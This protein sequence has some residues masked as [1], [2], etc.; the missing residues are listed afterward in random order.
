M[1]GVIELALIC[2]FAVVY[3]W[4]SYNLPILAAGVRN[5]IR[6]KFEA[7]SAVDLWSFAFCSGYCSRKE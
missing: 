4:V 7:R 6:S 3:V 1:L 5:L 2:V